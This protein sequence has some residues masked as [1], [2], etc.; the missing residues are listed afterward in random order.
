MLYYMYFTAHVYCF[1]R[2]R[3]RIRHLYLYLYL[4]AEKEKESKSKEESEWYKIEK[5]E[6][7]PPSQ[8]KPVDQEPLWQQVESKPNFKSFGSGNHSY[9]AEFDLEKE[10][11][12]I[13]ANLEREERERQEKSMKVAGDGNE[14]QRKMEEW[15]KEQERKL[16]V[17]KG[18]SKGGRT[19]SQF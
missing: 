2:E 13:I 9:R 10:E 4:F 11:Q 7:P 17:W 16:Q 6:L 18:Y 5:K 19:D 12:E 8:S 15:N 14:E 3:K 1:C